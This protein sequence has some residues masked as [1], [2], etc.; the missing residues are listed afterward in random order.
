[1]VCV[2]SIGD[3]LREVLLNVLCEGDG[4]LRKE[5]A[6]ELLGRNSSDMLLQEPKS[7]ARR[8]GNNVRGS[9]VFT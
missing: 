8:R 5:P 3:G 6:L 2:L 1:M 7:P 4:V 9:V